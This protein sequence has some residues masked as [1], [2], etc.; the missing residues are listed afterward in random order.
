VKV[1]ARRVKSLRILE[2]RGLSAQLRR[3]HQIFLLSPANLAGLRASYILGPT[4][5]S[6][7]ACRLRQDGVTLGELFTFI[8]GLYFRGKLVYAQ[9]FCAPPLD[10][11]GAFVI[12][13][14]A[15]LVSPQTVVTL[16]QL[17]EMSGTDIDA[18]EQR[19]RTPLDRDCHSLAK[20]LGESCDIVLLGS[21]ASAKY[22]EPLLDIF[23]ERL[24][25]PA[26]FVGRGDMSRGGLMLRSVAISKE[27]EYVPVLNATR[28]GRRP[29]KLSP[30]VVARAKSKGRISHAGTPPVAPG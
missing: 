29:P 21:I 30:L 1:A 9:A 7:L 28:H 24:L 12:T 10:I 2:G 13:A 14:S 19:Y 15:G 11:S 16:D 23:G 18:G 20:S 3:K 17:R 27:L 22:V 26:E 5:R 8:S 4:G 25:F 6:D